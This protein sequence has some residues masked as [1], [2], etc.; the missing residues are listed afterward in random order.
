MLEGRNIR[1][2]SQIMVLV[3]VLELLNIVYDLI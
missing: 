1:L 2:K 3:I